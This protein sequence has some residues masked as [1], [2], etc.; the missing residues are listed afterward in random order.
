MIGPITIFIYDEAQNIGYLLNITFLFDR[1][2]GIWP[3][4]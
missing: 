1:S 2:S 4:K 3:V